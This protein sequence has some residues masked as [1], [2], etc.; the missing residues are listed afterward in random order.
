[1]GTALLQRRHLHIHYQ[2]RGSPEL[3]VEVMARLK[4][5]LARMEGLDE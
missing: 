5:G 2:A 4:K 3:E 1:L